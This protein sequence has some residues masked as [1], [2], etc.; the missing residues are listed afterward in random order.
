MTRKLVLIGVLVLVL[1][2]VGTGIAFAAGGVGGGGNLSGPSADRAGE[3]ALA[4]TG[5]GEVLEV[6]EG[7]DPGPAYEVEIR[8]S[9]GAVKEVLLDGDFNV[10]DTVTGD[11][12]GKENEQ[13]ENEN[14]D[15][16]GENE[17]S[18]QGS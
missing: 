7:D 5:G 15:K 17:Q 11:D 2:A 3:V 9:D 8:T 12:D 16:D 6:E 1:A 18:G 10:I 13:N 14:E 4:S